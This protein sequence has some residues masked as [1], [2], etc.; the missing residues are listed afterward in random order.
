MNGIYRIPQPINDP[1]RTYSPGSSER[2]SIKKKLVSMSSEKIDIPLLIGGKEVRTGETATQVMPHRHGHVLAT[3]HKAGAKE[4]QM[5]VQAAKEA[6]REWSNWKLEDRAAIFLRAAELLVGPWRDTINGATMLCQSKT[7]HQAE[8]DAACESVDFLRFNAHYAEKLYGEQ[9][10]SGPGMWNRLEY[11]PLEGFVYTVTPFNFTSIGTNLSSAPAIMG[12]TVVWKPA[13]TTVYSNYFVTRLFEAA[14]LP[15]GVINFVPGNASTV[16]DILL[17]DPDL[18]GIHFTGSTEVFQ[19]MW[20]TV[21]EKISTY[22]SY[23]RLVGETGGKDFIVAHASADPDALVTAF[24]RGAY[25]YQGQKC[26][27]ASRVYVPDTLWKK[28]KDKL[29]DTINSISMGDVSDFRNFMGA[30]IDRNSFK[31]LSGYI[32]EAK[33]SSDAQ[34]IAGGE[35][36]ESV[37]YFVRPTLIQAKRPDYRTMCEELFG[38]VLSLYVYPENEFSQILDI[39]DKTSPYG[40]T[41]SIFASDR[42]AVV[43]AQQRLRYAAGNFYINDKPTGAVVGQQPFGGGRASGTNDKAGSMFNLIRWVSV[44]T[45]KETFV[46]PTD[47]RYPF[48]AE[49]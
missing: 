37:G 43:E 1:V 22:K 7:I 34:I 30:V 21:G 25:E 4:I 48:L 5:A 46:P 12:N 24:V 10:L 15:P 44:R 16:S 32:D 9:P 2:Q 8:I 28:I 23:P 26:S 47:Y 27:A 11:R 39:V 33:R 49:E 20:K 38:P 42:R 29:I 19:T 41:G 35:Y 45:I 40:L 3:W 13:S 36:D 18:A 31:K 14:G 6:H 17:N